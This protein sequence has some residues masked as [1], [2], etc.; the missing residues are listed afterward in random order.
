MEQIRRQVHRLTRQIN[1]LLEVGRL[2]QG[3]V[4]LLLEDVDLAELA[5]AAVGRVY[6][7]RAGDVTLNAPPSLMVRGDRTRLAEVVDGL[8]DNATR[9]TPPGTPVEV[10]VEERDGGAAVT[11]SDRGPGVPPEEVTTLFSLGADKGARRGRL[12]L[13]LGLHIGR[14]VARLH[15][16]DLAYERNAPTGARFTLTLPR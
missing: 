7:A 12:G 5:R 13:G 1:E 8:V 2:R 3:R 6:A 11:V 9:F 10:G 16:G 14:A 15:G 4:E